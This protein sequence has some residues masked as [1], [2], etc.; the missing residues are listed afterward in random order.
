MRW[1]DISMNFVED[2]HAGS[3]KKI[4]HRCADILIEKNLYMKELKTIFN[5]I[6]SDC[7]HTLY[8]LHQLAVA[9]F[10]IGRG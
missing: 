7:P 8:C 10:M 2:N 1:T 4:F 5:Y 3:K 9:G 6:D